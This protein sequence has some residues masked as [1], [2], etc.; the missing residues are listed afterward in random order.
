MGMVGGRKVDKARVKSRTDWGDS[1]PAAR[2]QADV[3]RPTWGGRVRLEGGRRGRRGQRVEVLLRNASSLRETAALPIACLGFRKLK[4]GWTRRSKLSHPPSLPPALSRASSRKLSEPTR[5]RFHPPPP[6][7]LA[8]LAPQSLPYNRPLRLRL[9]ATTPRP[10]PA[11]LAA[12]SPSLR[13]VHQPCRFSVP[14]RP[15]EY[16]LWRA[17]LH[18][19]LSSR[20]V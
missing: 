4:R 18:P 15:L 11:P 5:P 20:L 9:A 13:V 3:E 17:R 6:L 7:S 8:P 12:A 19:W 2:F 14:R 16:H 10:R 1:I